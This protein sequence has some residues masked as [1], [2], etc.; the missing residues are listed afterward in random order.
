M[1]ATGY[2]RRLP[3]ARRWV[4][5]ATPT[6]TVQP[7]AD[8]H[9][10]PARLVVPG[11]RGFWWVKWVVAVEPTDEP[12]WLAAAAAPA[13]TAVRSPGRS[14]STRCGGRRGVCLGRSHGG[15][16]GPGTRGDAGLTAVRAGGDHVQADVAV[17]GWWSPPGR[18][19]GTERCHSRTAPVFVSTTALNCM[20]AVA[21]GPAPVERVLAERAADAATRAGGVDHEARGRDVRAAAVRFGPIF[22]VPRTAP[23][24]SAT[25][26]RP[27]AAPSRA[28]GR[29]PRASRG[30]A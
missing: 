30:E 12:W 23:P 29:R 9:G 25:T 16:R 28:R 11:R 19:P 18:S 7:L 4:L 3:E 21:V 10:G 5:L 1:S 22:A 14:A 8:G 13:V 15:I 27:A 20:L 2:R 6:W 24:S 17:V 26:V